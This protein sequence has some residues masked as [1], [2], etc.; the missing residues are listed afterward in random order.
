MKP[1]TLVI[2]LVVSLALNLFLAGLIVGGGVVAR[3]M[4]E[5]RPP[6]AAGARLPLWRAG[7]DLPPVKRRAFR[8]MFRQAVRASEPDIR[9]SRA[10]KREAIASLRSPDYDGEAAVAAMSRARAQEMQAR[11]GVESAIL[12]FAQTLTPQER[13][14][15]SDRLEQSLAG[16]LREPG[17]R[18]GQR[19]GPGRPGPEG[20]PEP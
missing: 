1:R 20:P 18:R 10:I 16:Q 9:Q 4:V 17:Q 2:G 15:L 8:Q 13:L 14:L 19:Q 3:R 12:R 11:S 6:A 5:L 7:D